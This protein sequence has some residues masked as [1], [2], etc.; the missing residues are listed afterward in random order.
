MLIEPYF[1]ETDGK[2]N[3]TR[4]QGSDFAKKIADDF[5]PIHNVDS[6]R[7]CVPGDLLFSLILTK[8]G[9]SNSMK[10]TF[11]GMVTNETKLALPADNEHLVICG[12]KGREYLDILRSGDTCND[13]SLIDNLIRSYVTFS[14]HTFPH[15]LIPLMQEQGVMIN[16]ARPMI[17]Y[18]SML[19]EMIR[20]DLNDIKLELDHEKTRL[21][22][23]GKRGTICLAF[24]LKSNGTIVGLGEKHM[25]LSGLRPY[26]NSAIEGVIANYE[27]TKK[28]YIDA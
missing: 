15:V 20:F 9:I 2:I 3:F 16:P 5:N 22:V 25:I 8:Y 23:N 10:F 28:S 4:Q 19:I 1:N 14:G 11:S 18:Q 12:E 21:D 13:H 7:F 17:M 27:A 24:N 6:K 26:E